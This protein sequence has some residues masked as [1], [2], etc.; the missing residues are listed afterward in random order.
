MSDDVVQIFIH[1]VAVTLGLFVLWS[2]MGA[3]R[4][5]TGMQRFHSA[6]AA[7]VISGIA[8]LIVRLVT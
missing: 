5:L 6:L 2:V 3:M 1:V 4:G 7:G 8:V